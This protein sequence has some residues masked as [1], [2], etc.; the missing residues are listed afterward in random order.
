MLSMQRGIVMTTAQC[1]PVAGGAQ[2]TQRGGAGTIETSVGVG[3]TCQ[4]ARACG[5]GVDRTFGKRT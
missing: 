1:E 3:D 2:R 5:D 4:R